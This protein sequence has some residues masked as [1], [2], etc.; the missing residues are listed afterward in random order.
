MKLPILAGVALVVTCLPT[1]ALAREAIVAS[2]SWYA[3]VALGRITFDEKA[4]IQV[5]RHPL[6]GADG[7]LSNNTTITAEF[8]YHIAPHLS[9]AAT[10]KQVQLVDPP[11]ERQVGCGYGRSPTRS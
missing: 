1:G 2:P 3:R 8:G 4:R 5:A 11:H 10:L 7:R 9:V 6:V